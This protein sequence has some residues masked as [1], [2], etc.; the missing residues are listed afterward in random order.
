MSNHLEEGGKG[1]SEREIMRGGCRGCRAHEV[2]KKEPKN[3]LKDLGWL[4]G[5]K[6]EEQSWMSDW[7]V[8]VVGIIH[9]NRCQFFRD[10]R[11]ESC[12]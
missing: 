1:N 10:K 3:N 9:R 5:G 6:G 4:G 12:F 8:G 7:R 2:G 11:S